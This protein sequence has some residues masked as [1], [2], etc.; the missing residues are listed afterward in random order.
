MKLQKL[1]Y[2]PCKLSGNSLT[3]NEIGMASGSKNKLSK[4]TFER[5]EG[6]WTQQSRAKR[7]RNRGGR[8]ADAGAE[9]IKC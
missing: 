4:R 7:W 1:Q 6:P 8:T 5:L 9:K 3:Q 2:H